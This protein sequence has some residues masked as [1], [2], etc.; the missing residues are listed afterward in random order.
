MMIS[1]NSN[2]SS[3]IKKMMAA[4]VPIATDG[5]GHSISSCIISA[6]AP[7]SDANLPMDHLLN[8]TLIILCH[9]KNTKD[10]VAC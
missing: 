4:R 3:P 5:M 2:S 7:L 1:A 6:N 9:H 8:D 10:T